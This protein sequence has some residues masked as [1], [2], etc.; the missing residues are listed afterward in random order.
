MLSCTGASRAIHA[1]V[2]RLLGDL[3]LMDREQ[4]GGLS[5]C[6]TAETP[7]SKAPAATSNQRSSSLL[8][9]T[10]LWFKRFLKKPDKQV[11]RLGTAPHPGSQQVS[12][13]CHHQSHCHCKCCCH[14]LYCSPAAASY[15]V[16]W[17]TA[18]ACCFS[19]PSCCFYCPSFPFYASFYAFSACPAW[20][21]ALPCI[22]GPP[23]PA[24]SPAFGLMAAAAAAVGAGAATLHQDPVLLAAA[25][26]AA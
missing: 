8:T 2:Q 21:C 17:K 12:Y 7:T 11:Y 1:K 22:G 26:F 18:C 3:I 19:L 9:A 20:C 24:E 15:A 5:H 25:L 14:C 23:M 16:C 6:S 13:H 10:V 4:L